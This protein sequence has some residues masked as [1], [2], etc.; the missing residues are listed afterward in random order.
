MNQQLGFFQEGVA[1]SNEL[2]NRFHNIRIWS[3]KERRAPHKPLLALWAIARCLKG[4]PRLAPFD[5]VDKEFATLFTQFGPS[6]SRPQ[7]SLPFWHMRN[8]GIWELD[9]PHLVSITP[10]GSAHKS[11]LMEHSIRGGFDKETYDTLRNDAELAHQIAYLLLDAHF[12]PSLHDDIL[13]AVGFGNA[14]SASAPISQGTGPGV[15]EEQAIYG[16]ARYRKRDSAFRAI[17]LDAYGHQ[18]AVCR[19]AVKLDDSPIAIDAAHIRWHTA[20]GP[21]DVPNGLSLCATHH[22]L[23]DGGA[24][25]ILQDMSVRVS[26]FAKGHRADQILRQYDRKNLQILPSYGEHRPRLEFLQWHNREV[27]RS[28]KDITKDVSFSP[29]ELRY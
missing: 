10:G 26:D 14:D 16:I 21:A 24:F 6:R 17:V 29:K 7:A 9:R 22:R 4:E 2:L 28:P 25:T 5:A 12:P 20:N 13:E 18:C 23:F 8:D 19:F 27:F 1:Q 15:N 3:D 11:A